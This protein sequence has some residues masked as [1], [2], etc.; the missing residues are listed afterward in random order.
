[1]NPLTP[2]FTPPLHVS[3]QE[4][5]EADRLRWNHPRS[6]SVTSVASTVS[7]GRCGFSK[8]SSPLWSPH[9]PT[10]DSCSPV[11]DKESTPS[12]KIRR[13]VTTIEE[14]IRQFEIGE[15][16]ECPALMDWTVEMRR[17]E[18]SIYSQRKKLYEEYQRLGSMEAFNA[19]YKNMS[20]G[21]I[22]AL[23]SSRSRHERNI[24]R[25]RA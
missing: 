10:P 5:Y 23:I 25:G 19:L 22:Y 12:Y 17:K 2:P 11:P 1:M 20:I 6:N 3:K 7:S 8:S 13:G 16:P 24:Q 4:R 9:L 21:K 14:V 15:G 18:R